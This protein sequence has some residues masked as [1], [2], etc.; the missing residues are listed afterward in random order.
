MMKLRIAGAELPTQVM[1]TERKAGRFGW[2]DGVR[3]GIWVLK[4]G[5]EEAQVASYLMPTGSPPSFSLWTGSQG[6]SRKAAKALSMA[7][8]LPTKRDAWQR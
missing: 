8:M 3:G 2:R 1:G 7:V 6:Q 4:G 5:L